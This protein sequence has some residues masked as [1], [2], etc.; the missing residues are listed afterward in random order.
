MNNNI[1]NKNVSTLDTKGF[2]TVC[3]EFREVLE[4]IR[5][6]ESFA[7]KLR[8]VIYEYK[9][10]TQTKLAKESSISPKTIES[11]LQGNAHKTDYRNIF[12]IAITLDL[13]HVILRELV[14]SVWLD[15]TFSNRVAEEYYIIYVMHTGR[16]HQE[17]NLECRKRGVPELFDELIDRNG[18]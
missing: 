2:I 6:S 12:A 9:K 1:E 15:A 10:T 17:M 4:R 5:N 8:L 18:Y 3:D 16:T 14:L 7:D 13:P 11:Y